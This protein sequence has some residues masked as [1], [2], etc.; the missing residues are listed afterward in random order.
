VRQVRRAQP[1]TPSGEIRVVVLDHTGEL[2][3][4]ELALIRLCGALRGR[5]AFHVLLFA[6]GPLRERLTALGATVEVLMLPE[7]V[8]RADRSMSG[9]P[10]AANLVRAVRLVPFLWR[11]MWRLRR[12]RPD[13]VHTTS[14]KADLLALPAAWLAGVPL[15]WHVH[16]RISPDYLPRP[17]VWLVRQASR[18][19]RAVIVNSRATGSTLPRPSCVAY[20]G[21]AAAQV[22]VREPAPMR[23]P[24]V[25]LIG[26]LSPTKGQ[27]EF[28]QAASLVS[29]SHPEVTFR[30]VGA[31][32]FGEDEYVREVTA[33]ARALA[34]D[35]RIEWIGRVDD[36]GA[37][38]DRMSVCVHASP[39]PEPFGQV[40]V[41]A[42]VRGVPVVATSAGGVPEI[43]TEDGRALGALVAP[44]DVPALADAITR[45][46]DDPDAAADTAREAHASA[47]RRFPVEKTA[48][49]VESVWRSVASPSRRW[50]R[51]SC[52]RAPRR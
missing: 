48:L 51:L 4:A 36:T 32:A 2:G 12:L 15:V 23:D 16:D 42:M 14:L 49:T 18:F 20:P 35:D 47:M 40:I 43:L 25:G 7:V 46:L 37:E 29:E 21:F 10:S 52:G 1:S 39:V 30:I 31:A 24:V 28:V 5:V 9:A 33:E 13:V 26:R 34:V 11:L 50:Y 3:G 44:G 27:R 45:V 41:E 6:D 19:P 17:L 22:A 8:A 38:L